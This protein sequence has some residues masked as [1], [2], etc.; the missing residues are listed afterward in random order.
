V[1]IDRVVLYLPAPVAERLR[2]QAK[3]NREAEQRW[4]LDE[5]TA[6]QTG[7]ENAQQLQALRR[8]VLREATAQRSTRWPSL[9][10]LATAAI[11]ARLAQPDVR[12]LG[13]RLDDEEQELDLATGGRRTGS[14]GGGYT[15]VVVSLPAELVMHGRRAAIRLS[16]QGLHDLAEVE[17]AFRRG[18][19]GER[20]RRQRRQEV[21]EHVTTW[22]DL[23]RQAFPETT[24][25]VNTPI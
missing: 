2:N 18:D 1:A 3:A 25:P 9:D 21:S 4:R 6:R 19:I 20:E 15:R 17:E 10:D 12:D 23:V 16:K 8:T 5:I 22:G 13:G 11:R 7:R 24:E 14:L